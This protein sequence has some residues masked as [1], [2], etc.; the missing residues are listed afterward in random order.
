LSNNIENRKRLFDKF[1]NQ[2]HLLKNEG[3]IDIELK[4]DKTYIC[5][6]CIRQFK[7]DDLIS[8]SKKNFLTEEDAP[9]EKLFGSRIALTCK[10]CNS[11]A[12]HQIDVH[13]INRIKQID[14]SRFYKGSKQEGFIEYKGKIIT[15][16]ITSNGDGILEILH[17]TKNNNPSILDKFLYGIKNKDIGPFLNLKPKREKNDTERVNLALIK[18]NYI[19]TFAKF[20]YIF[21][22]DKYYDS[23]REQ[24]RVN[25]KN[26]DGHI[27]LQ[28]Q[29][30]KDK[31]GTFYVLNQN[32]KSIFNVFSLKTDY[33]ETLIGAILPL[34]G[35]T[36][37]DIRN[38]LISKGRKKG[39]KEKIGVLL[40]TSNYD[41]NSDVFKNLEEINKII[42]WKDGI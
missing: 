12:G 9:P 30:P 4:F 20:G 13:L 41:P 16:E 26:Y 6:I 2:L 5:P 42:K 37:T 17:K 27:F 24:I 1:S 19:L 29:F 8:N 18:T 22:L 36:P 32:A 34:P 38:S 33:S 11:K 31:I 25:S 39:E 14:S 15:A 28:D 10:E 35:R 23:L 3:L 21:L 40:K 7:E